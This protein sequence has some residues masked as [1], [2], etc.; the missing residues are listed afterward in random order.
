[1]WGGALGLWFSH[2]FFFCMP[3]DVL[4]AVTGRNHSPAERRLLG[5]QSILGHTAHVQ[6]HTHTIKIDTC[7]NTH[8]GGQMSSV[9][10]TSATCHLS[11][12]GIKSV[13]KSLSRIPGGAVSRWTHTHTHRNQQC[14]HFSRALTALFDFIL[15]TWTSISSHIPF[16]PIPLLMMSQRPL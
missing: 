9:W 5:R 2:G 1:M 11:N 15:P 8:M 12:N 14:I 6:I 13:N 16:A 3:W 10:I 7:S 4:R